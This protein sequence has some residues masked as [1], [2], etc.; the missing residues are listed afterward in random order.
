MKTILKSFLM[1]LGVTIAFSSCSDW[2]ETEIKDPE[3]LTDAQKTEK[4]YENLRAYKKT[5]HPVAFGWF[6]EWVGSGA[7]LE[8]SLRGLPDSVDFVSIWGNWKNLDE[9]RIADKKY[10]NPTNYNSL[11]VYIPFIIFMISATAL[12]LAI[13]ELFDD[14]KKAFFACAVIVS[15]IMSRLTLGFSPTVFASG[16]RTFIFLDF[17]IIYILVY[18]SEEYGARIKARSGAVAILRALMILMVIVAVV[19]NVI[20]VCNVYLY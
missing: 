6:G 1:F 10:V 11:A 8:H 9:A 17:A 19:A 3:N 16:K 7:S 2:T 13:I 4:Y 18:L 5:D 20:A 14:E 12:L 15:G